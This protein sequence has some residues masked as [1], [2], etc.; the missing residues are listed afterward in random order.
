MLKKKYFSN[1]YETKFYDP[2]IGHSLK[3]PPIYYL[4]ELLNKNIN[5][6]GTQ[7]KLEIN[8][9]DASIKKTE[10]LNND[11]TKY[12]EKNIF[13]FEVNFLVEYI[14]LDDLNLVLASTIIEANRSTTSSRYISLNE[15]SKII[16]NLI[17]DCLI[18]FSFKTKELTEI[19]MNNFLL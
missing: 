11:N 17:Y 1:L 3:N 5:I 15:T 7:N 16:D 6:F 2:Y 14:L 8:I 12:K 13:L 18:D 19:H 10:I 4:N 9:I